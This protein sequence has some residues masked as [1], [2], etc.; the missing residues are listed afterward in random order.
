MEIDE[1]GVRNGTYTI[2]SVK[3]LIDNREVKNRQ[4]RN[5]L[6]QKLT[7]FKFSLSLFEYQYHLD[8]SILYHLFFYFRSF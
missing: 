4:D 8:T 5:F 1:N 7:V 6:E 3:L 2:I